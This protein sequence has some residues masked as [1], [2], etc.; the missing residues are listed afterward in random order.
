MILQLALD[1]MSIPEAVR[2]AG[3]T[4]E[5][6]DWIE[7]GTSIIKEFGM[8]GVRE[9]KRAF[10]D[11]P[12]V[13][14]TKTMDNARYEFEKAFEAGADAATVMGVAPPVTIETCM[15]VARRHGKTV[16]IDLL[17][18]S[19]D[20]VRE[21]LKYDEAVFCVHVSKDE[22]E[23]GVRPVWKKCAAVSSEKPVKWAAAGGITLSSLEKV[24]K[25]FHPSVVIVGT[26]IT[27]AE[28]PKEAAR[29]LKQAIEKGE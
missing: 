25:S 16:M 18:V 19:E 15:D 13:A 29:Q 4:E 2:L 14:D 17:N 24:R 23:E 5:F 28:N 27:K 6:T 8:A 1:R 26:A 22:Q 3:E 11:K 20:Q 7:V 12:V 21:L 10:P 9:L